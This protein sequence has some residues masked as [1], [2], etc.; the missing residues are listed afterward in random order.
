VAPKILIIGFDNWFNLKYRKRIFLSNIAQPYQVVSWPKQNSYHSLCCCSGL[1][2]LSWERV[3]VRLSTLCT[4]G[5]YTFYLLENSKRESL[6]FRLIY[7]MSL[8]WGSGLIPQIDLIVGLQTHCRNDG[9]HLD[10][11]LSTKVFLSSRLK[12]AKREPL[13]FGA[14]STSDKG[15]GWVTDFSAK[16]WGGWVPFFWAGR[17][18]EFGKYCKT[19]DLDHFCC[20]KSS[21]MPKTHLNYLFRPVL[22]DFKRFFA[23][24]GSYRLIL[25]AFFTL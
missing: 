14:R 13:I 21:K 8:L 6:I 18:K 4:G 10:W 16:G 19:V 25:G 9:G 24:L 7:I 20:Y 15:W 2:Q 17:K 23:I 12:T 22:R 5:K 11:F 1:S 3:V